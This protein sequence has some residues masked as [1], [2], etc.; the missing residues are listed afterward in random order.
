MR[1]QR[2][3]TTAMLSDLK[4]AHFWCHQVPH[5]AA[6]ITMGTSSLAVMW[7]ACQFGSQANWN[8]PWWTK[9]APQPNVPEASEIISTEGETGSWKKWSTVPVLYKNVC[10]NSKSALAPLLIKGAKK[11][12]A[13][14]NNCSSVREVD[15]SISRSRLVRAQSTMSYV[16]AFVT[17]WVHLEVVK[18][19]RMRVSIS[20]YTEEC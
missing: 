18:A 7:V 17:L 5:S 11:C 4:C 19:R 12:V 20:S 10:H 8:Q 2:I 14:G 6:E 13:L 3:W 9:K 15:Q 16:V 1:L